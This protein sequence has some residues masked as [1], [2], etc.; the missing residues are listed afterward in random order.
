MG[1]RLRILRNRVVIVSKIDYNGILHCGEGGDVEQVAQNSITTP[2]V[3]DWLS[4]LISPTLL[5]IILTKLYLFIFYYYKIICFI[6]AIHQ[7]SN[8]TPQLLF[9]KNHEEKFND[10]H[11]GYGFILEYWFG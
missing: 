7:E 1:L 3:C 10:R 11:R 2:Y 5:F 4:R 9:K 8:Y 6:L